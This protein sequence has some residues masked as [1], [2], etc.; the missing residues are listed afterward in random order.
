MAVDDGLANHIAIGVR[1]LVGA[2][3][4]TDLASKT[5]R[6]LAGNWRRAKGRADFLMATGRSQGARGVVLRIFRAY[7]E[8]YSPRDISA[9]LNVDRIAPRA[10]ARGSPPRAAARGTHR[11]SMA[12]PSAPR[13]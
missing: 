2:L 5:R 12:R 4:L 7:A 13:A 9:S 6:G 3:Y 1:G 8:G 10:A 11:P